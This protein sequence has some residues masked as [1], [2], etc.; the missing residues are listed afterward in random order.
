MCLFCTVND[1]SSLR[2]FYNLGVEYFKYLRDVHG[3]GGV[4]AMIDGDNVNSAY[5]QSSSVA[6]DVDTTSQHQLANDF[7]QFNLDTPEIETQSPSKVICTYTYVL[8]ISFVY[9]QQKISKSISFLFKLNF[10]HLFFPLLRTFISNSNEATLMVIVVIQ[11][12][13]T[14][15]T[16]VVHSM[17]QSI[18][19]VHIQVQHGHTR[20]I[21]QNSAIKMQTMVVRT[22][23]M[24][25][26]M[27][28][29]TA[30]KAHR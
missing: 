14:N 23:A 22:M 19:K 7:Q 12:R 16:I 15:E 30:M 3:Y 9:L 5:D 6:G 26:A 21:R 20:K 10:I 25:M 2:F 8:V 17:A 13:N 11:A 29:Q 27:E 4:M 18:F 24:E 28:I 1:K